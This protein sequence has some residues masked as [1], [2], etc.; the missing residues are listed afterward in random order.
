MKST[1]DCGSGKLVFW[2]AAAIQ[3][4]LSCHSQQETRLRRLDA[5]A[6]RAAHRHRRRVQPHGG[7]ARQ[8]GDARRRRRGEHARHSRSQVRESFVMRRGRQ[9]KKLA[10]STWREIFVIGQETARFNLEGN[11][12]NIAR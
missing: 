7:H 12:S 6:A 11:I 8:D 5:V 3:S 1:T 10:A 2:E 9:V 4:V